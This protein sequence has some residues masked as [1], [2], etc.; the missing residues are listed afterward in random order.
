MKFFRV[1]KSL[2][3]E[4]QQIS[5]PIQQ[6]DEID[7]LA[8]TIDDNISKEIKIPK[9]VLNSFKIKDS[10]NK[11]IWQDNKLNPKV[12][13]KLVN[14]AKDFM[15]DIELPKGIKIK[16]IIFTGSLA[17]YNWSK[18]SDIDLHIVLDFKQ[19][20]ADQKLVDDFFYAQKS[21]WNQEHD[22]TV[23]DYPVEL[24]VQDVNHELV[25]NAVYSVLRDKW[26]KNPKREEFDVDKKAIKD[27]AEKYIHYLK[28]IRQDYQDKKYQNVVDK[29]TKLKNKIKNMRK[30]GLESGGEYSYENLVFKVLR[31]TP[32]MDILDSYKAKSY[33]NLMSVVENITENLS[34]KEEQIIAKYRIGKDSRV[35]FKNDPKTYY[36]KNISAD[37]KN[38]F[39][40]L[41][42]LQTYSKRISNLVKVN[43]KDVVI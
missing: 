23:F 10:L 20:E 11:D 3:V 19:F 28:D 5:L 35:Q 22:I 32:F 7:A 41:N 6:L 33:D 21:I 15:R 40:T 17:N 16:D 39:V 8:S 27:G 9:D 37:R 42:M 31:R 38:L 36:V 1:D 25:A 13:T 34:S 4:N 14:I 2:L 12:R 18:F 26:I 24:Y 43:D 29:V 30:A